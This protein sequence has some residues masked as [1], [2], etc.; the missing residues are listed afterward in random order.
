M[1]HMRGEDKGW[2]PMILKI[3]MIGCHGLKY[4]FARIAL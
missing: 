3:L 2:D 4:P 1:K